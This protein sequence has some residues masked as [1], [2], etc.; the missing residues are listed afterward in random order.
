MEKDIRKA[1]R[2]SLLETAGKKER[3]TPQLPPVG[4]QA[5][6][7]LAPGKLPA[8]SY[9]RIVQQKRRHRG[10]IVKC[11]DGSLK[12]I[13]EVWQ[14]IFYNNENLL[15]T[16]E[17][18][19]DEMNRLFPNRVVSKN[20]QDVRAQRTHYNGGRLSGML[21]PPAVRS[22]RYEV[23][24]EVPYRLD[25]RGKT[26]GIAH[27]KMHLMRK[28]SSGLDPIPESEGLSVRRMLSSDDPKQRNWSDL[29]P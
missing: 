12:S 20:F 1:I 21:G 19:R 28:D 4:R 14:T 8:P 26:I 5:I 6:P 10:Q 24:D 11:S 9:I 2:D 17:E 7:P 15:C 27:D 25:S 16:D 13:S 29:A 22:Y 23:R 3:D 18:I